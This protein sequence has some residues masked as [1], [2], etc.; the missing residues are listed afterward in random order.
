MKKT[1][2]I[3][4]L[5][6][7]I[8]A[9]SLFSGCGKEE[10]AADSSGVY[11]C[12]HD[13]EKAAKYLESDD[14]VLVVNGE[15]MNWEEYLPWLRY[16]IYT[17]EA[18]TGTT[19]TD[20]DAVDESLGCTYEEY[21]LDLV[22]YNLYQYK[23]IEACAPEFGGSLT[24]EDEDAMEEE[25]ETSSESYGGEDVFAG[26]IDEAFGSREFYDYLLGLSYMYNN[27]YESQYGLKGEKL[28]DEDVLDYTAGDGYMM[29]KHI[30]FMT[31]DRTT[32]EPL[33]DDEIAKQ[34]ETA[35]EILGDLRAYEGDD[36]EGYFTELM[37]EYSEDTGLLGFPD[38]YLF[39][40]GEMVP[41]FEEATLSQGEYEISDIV[42][43]TYGYHIVMT[44][45]INV[46]VV[47]SAYSSYGSDYTLRYITAWDMYNA[48]VDEW[49][50]AT[51]IEKTG[52]Y[53][54]INLSEVFGE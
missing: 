16:S 48:Q 27:A 13:F 47:P 24:E 9:L 38:G 3:A 5:L 37:N 54:R 17:Y 26:F 29:A 32:N 6:G 21:I 31:V 43:T 23:G 36:I 53:D 11:T 46:D 8:L 28:S 44:L 7:L 12:V 14:V 22:D 33:P 18:Q 52:D 19:I 34:R 42:E 30:L 2:V 41:E 15:E 20:W 39:Q 35:E 50:A 40:T 51:I 45:P 1:R 49:V 4:L 10:E 25:W